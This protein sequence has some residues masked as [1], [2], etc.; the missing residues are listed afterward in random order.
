[1]L[2]YVPFLKKLSWSLHDLNA[3]ADIAALWRCEQLHSPYGLTYSLPAAAVMALS[4]NSL[5][6][7]VLF[8]NIPF[9]ILL[10]ASVYLLGRRIAGS[11]AGLASAVLLALYPAVFGTSRMYCPDFASMAIT[12]LSILMLLQCEDFTKTGYSVLYGAAAAW[13]MLTKTESVAF[14]AG[15][16]IFIVSK[17][18]YPWLRERSLA[19]RWRQP[20]NILL[21]LAAWYFLA[22]GRMEQLL[23]KIGGL[24]GEVAPPGINFTTYT[25]ELSECMLGGF[26]SLAFLWGAAVFFRR[27]AIP[28]DTKI[29]C[30]LWLLLPWSILVMAPHRGTHLYA[31]MYLPDI[32]LMSAIGIAGLRPNL[33]RV[34]MSALLAV[35]AVQYYDFSFTGGP[36]LD[37]L[38]WDGRPGWGPSLRYFRT[39][40]DLCRRM[41]S[42]TQ[43]F[44]VLEAIGSSV[45]KRMAEY[46]GRMVL[47]WAAN[48][49]LNNKYGQPR[50][51]VL[52]GFRQA[53]GFLASRDTPL[54]FE[55]QIVYLMSVVDFM[56]VSGRST[57]PD[58]ASASWFDKNLLPE[59]MADTPPEAREFIKKY[60]AELGGFD[61]LGPRHVASMK[62]YHCARL[63]E[64]DDDYVAFC[65]RPPGPVGREERSLLSRLPIEH[66]I[67]ES[68]LDLAHR[69]EEQSRWI[70]AEQ[71][72]LQALRIDPKAVYIHSDLARLNE[73]RGHRG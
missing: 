15:P 39:H 60:V 35:G 67:A 9:F 26:F 73:R 65:Q 21:G 23:G 31:L 61:K 11:N 12:T 40:N 63:Y 53:P 71:A 42:A 38:H 7:T 47:V 27:A 41:G 69:Y 28:R 54:I 64:N 20:C 45:E 8:M 4:N 19:G 58:L 13:G 52:E 34:M 3:A 16:T 17:A 62:Q 22:G 57:D 14:L 50:W 29:V 68:Y 18:L 33:R 24:A 51:S 32:A 56:L 70:K 30:A 46:P 2:P 10:L 1:M 66:Y 48:R 44:R 59:N 49:E 72:Y 36:H 43:A 37:R 6:K 5:L 25:L 55:P